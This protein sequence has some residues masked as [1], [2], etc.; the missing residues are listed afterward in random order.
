MVPQD[1]S[2]L[3]WPLLNWPCEQQFEATTSTRTPTI[4]DE[5]DCRQEPNNEQAGYG[6]STVSSREIL[7]EHLCFG[8]LSLL[9][10]DNGLPSQSGPGVFTFHN[11]LDWAFAQTRKIWRRFTITEVHCRT[12]RKTKSEG[13]RH[14]WALIAS[15]PGYLPS[16]SYIAAT[17]NKYL[18][19]F[20]SNEYLSL[21]TKIREM[22]FVTIRV[23]LIGFFFPAEN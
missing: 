8:G 20:L 23:R 2:S 22:K 12:K 15:V 1:R 9:T 7:R 18:E 19:R 6:S 13:Q 21:M 5:F 14:Q 4:G 3:K 16:H 11:K 10:I 17:S